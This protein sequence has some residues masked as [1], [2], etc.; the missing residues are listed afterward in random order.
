MTKVRIYYERATEKLFRQRKNTLQEKAREA[1]EINF[2]F[3]L[4]LVTQS[5]E[6]CAPHKFHVDE[7]AEKVGTRTQGECGAA[8][9]KRKGLTSSAANHTRR[10][11]TVVK[12]AAVV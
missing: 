10:N 2:H 7:S 1:V 9:D 6:V 3:R 12:C 8:K 5:T 4:P 11:V